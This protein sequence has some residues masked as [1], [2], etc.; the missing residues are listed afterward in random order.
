MSTR[1]GQ[2]VLDIVGLKGAT[3]LGTCPAV[4]DQH[5]CPRG[6]KAFILLL[7]MPRCV[8]Q[9]YFVSEV[10][11]DTF[12]V[13]KAATCIPFWDSIAFNVVS[14]LEPVF[15]EGAYNLPLDGGWRK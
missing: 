4:S 8:E 13:A 3:T 10:I 5:C 6:S 11:N 15:E 9:Y 1:Q 7:L 2:N 14:H 12:E